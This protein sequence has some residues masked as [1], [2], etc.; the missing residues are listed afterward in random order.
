MSYKY[1]REYADSGE[2]RYSIHTKET[3]Y[4]PSEDDIFNPIVIVDNEVL[5]GYNRLNVLKSMGVDEVN[6]F[7]S[8]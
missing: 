8:I 3:N 2:N 5:D 1:Y 4:T 6:A 7:V